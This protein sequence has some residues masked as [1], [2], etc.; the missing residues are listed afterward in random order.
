MQILTLV[1]QRYHVLYYS[2][3]LLLI[4]MLWQVLDI[5][6]QDLS[7]Q[8]ELL[9]DSN[10]KTDLIFNGTY[11]GQYNMAFLGPDDILVVEG[12]NGTIKRILNGTMLQ[13]PLLD[14]NVSDPDGLLGIVISKEDRSHTYVFIYYTAAPKGYDADVRWRDDEQRRLVNNTFGYLRECDCLYR[15]ELVDNKLINPKPIL[16]LPAHPGGDEHHGGEIVIGPD[17]NVYIVRGDLAGAG[18]PETKAQNFKN[19][20]EPDGRAGILVVSQDGEPRGTGILG[21]KFPLN[22]YYAYGI[23]NSFGMDFDQV[24]GMLWDTENGPDYGDEINLVEPRFNSGANRFHGMSSEDDE[25]ELE[26]LVDFGGRGIY[27]DPEFAWQ[28]PVAPTAIKFLNSDKL[29]RNY[30]NDIFVADANNGNIYHFDLNENRTELSLEPGPLA[31]KIADDPGELDSVI[32]ARG[33][34]DSITDLQVGPDG[35]LY[36]LTSSGENAL[37]YRITPN[38]S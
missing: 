14:V 10:L 29:G 4:V 38:I 19:G 8:T 5:D 26:Q 7:A 11:S 13:Q 9:T 2:Y 30:Q 6:V 3:T 27:S 17:R 21:D 15:Y 36:V 16:S 20:T 23:R 1:A 37:I 31:D 28:F 22:L 34:G 35:Y 25:F 12:V 33:L 24:T 32:F 18:D